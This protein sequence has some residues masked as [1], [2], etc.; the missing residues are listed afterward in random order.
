MYGRYCSVRK[1]KIAKF[2]FLFKLICAESG[3]WKLKFM[4]KSLLK[5]NK[6]EIN[7][8]KLYSTTM[9]VKVRQ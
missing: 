3:L 1:G 8:V 6:K 4:V 9:C 7:S 5:I 2:L